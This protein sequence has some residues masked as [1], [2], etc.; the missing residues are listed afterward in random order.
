M[1]RPRTSAWHP[2]VPGTRAPPF[3]DPRTRTADAG[4]TA[5]SEQDSDTC[6]AVMWQ[7]HAHVKL[8]EEYDEHAP[9]PPANRGLIARGASK[10]PSAATVTR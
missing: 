1:C 2:Q 3:T 4:G 9:S 10:F 6:G 7:F 8:P 5:L